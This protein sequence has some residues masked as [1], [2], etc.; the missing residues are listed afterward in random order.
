M[1]QEYEATILKLTTT[2]AGLTKRQHICQYK[3]G[4]ILSIW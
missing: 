4:V 2:I 3:D 1:T